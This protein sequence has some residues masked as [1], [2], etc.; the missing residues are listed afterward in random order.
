MTLAVPMS[1]AALI[2]FSNLSVYLR[3][4]L[5]IIF[6]GFGLFAALVPIQG[7]PLDKWIVLFARAIMAPTQRVWVKDAKLPE[8]LEVLISRPRKA[9]I[10]LEPITAGDKERLKAYLRALPKGQVSPFDVREQI[11]I[12]RLNLSTEGAGQGKLPPAVLW[13]KSNAPFDKRNIALP[14][15]EKVKPIDMASAISAGVGMSAREE[16]YQGAMAAALP[17]VKP[18][19][20]TGGR[21]KIS[22]HAK[23]YVLPGIEKRLGEES[24]SIKPKVQLASDTNFAIENVIPIT[25]PGRRV[26]LVRGVGKSRARKLHFAPPVGFDLANLPIRGEARFEVSD[27]LKKGL[28]PSLFEEQKGRGLAFLKVEKS[29]SGKPVVQSTLVGDM[30]KFQHVS[31]H[32]RLRAAAVS[33]VPV[34][35]DLSSGETKMTVGG[36]GPHGET[37]PVELLSRAQIVP[38]TNKP[39]VLSGLVTD[40]HG[41]PVAGAIVTVRDEHGVPVRALKTNKLGQFLSATPLVSGTYTLDIDGTESA[42][43]PIKLNIIGEVLAPLSIHPKS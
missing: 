6:G 18:I 25:T 32:T 8:F 15:V 5:A 28:D 23:A 42:F 2:F 9:Q 17:Q 40:N 3:Y 29:E 10:Q 20:K 41:A 34:G 22:N 7:R 1:F 26:R 19:P 31:G 35:P 21:V 14:Q 38:L 12:E 27:Q 43:E 13:T 30:R 36:D 37:R 33:A 39:N 16:D 4:P 11:A 24:F